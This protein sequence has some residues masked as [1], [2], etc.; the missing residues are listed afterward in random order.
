MT[1]I[2]VAN[3]ILGISSLISVIIMQFKDKRN[4]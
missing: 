3:V 4:L 2:I 1:N